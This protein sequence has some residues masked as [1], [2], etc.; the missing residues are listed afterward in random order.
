MTDIL[1]GIGLVGAAVFFAVATACAQKPSG[2]NNPLQSASNG[3]A[4]AFDGRVEHVERVDSS[5]LPAWS[6]C[7]TWIDTPLPLFRLESEST[8]ETYSY[9]MQT[10]GAR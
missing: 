6:T 5:S 4:V 7:S 2:T 8:N 10:N 9:A 1:A 3:L